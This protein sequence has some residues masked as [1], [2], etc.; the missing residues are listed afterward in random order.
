MEFK[1]ALTDGNWT[2]VLPNVVGDGTLKAL[3][4]SSAARRRKFAGCAGIESPKQ[5]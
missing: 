1:G 5:S 2:D 4:D 3:G